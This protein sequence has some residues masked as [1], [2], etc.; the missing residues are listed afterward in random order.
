MTGKGHTTYGSLMAIDF[1]AG[2]YMA[3]SKFPPESA[4]GHIVSFAANAFDPVANFEGIAGY[5]LAGAAIALYYIGLLLPDIDTT[6]TISGKLH[7]KL[8]FRHRGVTH[9]IW[10]ICLFLVPSLIWRQA[11][12]LRYLALGMLCHDFADS[13]SKSGWVPFYPLGRYMVVHKSTVYSK[14]RHITLYASDREGSENT[15]IAVFGV[16]SAAAIAAAIIFWY[17]I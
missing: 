3:G 8:P 15:M 10:A 5:L 9:S 1:V 11:W 13:F 16:I 14:R 7:F 6:S 17:V 12:I 4:V 2:Y